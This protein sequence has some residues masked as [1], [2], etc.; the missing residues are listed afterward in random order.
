MNNDIIYTISC[1]RYIHIKASL[2]FREPSDLLI[3]I[4]NVYY[5]MCY[6]IYVPL[7][8]S[9]YSH[10]LSCFPLVIYFKQNMFFFFYHLNYIIK[11]K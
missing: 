6:I 5:I 11:I 4:L 7:C 2:K 8:T 3:A 1:Y 9:I 10:Y